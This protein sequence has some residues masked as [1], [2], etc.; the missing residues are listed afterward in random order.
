[1]REDAVKKESHKPQITEAAKSIKRQESV[2]DSLMRRRIEYEYK[3]DELRKEK[4]AREVCHPFS[5]CF[6]FC[7]CV[8]SWNTLSKSKSPCLNT[9][10]I[11]RRANSLHQRLVNMRDH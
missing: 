5:E 6:L 3:M 4:E 9:T 1:M 11:C 10:T 7:G 2:V 8:L